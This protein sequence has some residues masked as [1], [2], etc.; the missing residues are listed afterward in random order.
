MVSQRVFYIDS[1]FFVEKE[2]PL[3]HT[4]RKYEKWVLLLVRFREGDEEGLSDW[5]YE[6]ILL[7]MLTL[8]D[9]TFTLRTRVRGI[10]RRSCRIDFPKN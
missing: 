3:T 10:I 7:H 4:L 6:K 2:N 8:R 5:K 9:L 1:Y